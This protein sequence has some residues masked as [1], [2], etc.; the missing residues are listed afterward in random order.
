VATETSGSQKK[1]GQ[2]HP[3]VASQASAI[4]AD[5]GALRSILASGRVQPEM[6]MSLQASHG[7]SAVQELLTPV[8]RA[9]GVATHSA[10]T[11][12][13]RAKHAKATHAPAQKAGPQ[14]ENPTYS[15][16]SKYVDKFFR[17]QGDKEAILAELKD[18][19]VGRF[20]EVTGEAFNTQSPGGLEILWDVLTIVPTAGPLLKTCG[21]LKNGAKFFVTITKAAEEVKKLKEATEVIEPFVKGREMVKKAA[22]GTEKHE[23]AE[24]IIEKINSL[25][26]LR[27]AD[28]AGRWNKEDAIDKLLDS[29]R[30]DP[31][32]VNLLSQFEAQLGRIDDSSELKHAAEEVRTK[33]ELALY[34]D[35]YRKQGAKLY[36]G[37]LFIV[38]EFVDGIPEEAKKYIK[39]LGGFSTDRELASAFRLPILRDVPLPESRPGEMA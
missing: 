18:H 13:A 5:P 20:K 31:A 23:G 16:A 14:I 32:Q 33:F 12:H 7:N 26:E 2:A 39:K 36:I 8:Q 24:F 15:P 38:A 17:R 28:V 22:E 1:P 10:R 19:A 4:H 35:F 34:A 30:Y 37:T 29:H 27:V 11:H 9:A 25:D 21:E 6:L 3:R